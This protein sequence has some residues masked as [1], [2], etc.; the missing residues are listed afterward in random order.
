MHWVP[1]GGELRW[2]Y[3]VSFL[4]YCLPIACLSHRSAIPYGDDLCCEFRVIHWL[5]LCCLCV[6]GMRMRVFV[7]VSRIKVSKMSRKKSSSF[8]S[9]PSIHPFIHS[10]NAFFVVQCWNVDETPNNL[11]PAEIPRNFIALVNQIVQLN[12]SFNKS[13]CLSLSYSLSVSCSL[14]SSSF[15]EC[16]DMMMLTTATAKLATLAH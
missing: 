2:L 10:F 8:I 12:S 9:F 16:D 1:Y 6:Y 14:H 11:Y 4:F 3:W 7:Y 15:D 5:R 13:L